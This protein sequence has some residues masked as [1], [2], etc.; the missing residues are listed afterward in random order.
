[1]A[2]EE[3][4][5]DQEFLASLRRL[6]ARLQQKRPL[7]R[8]GAQITPS[9]GAS[10]EFKDRRSYVAGD[11]YRIIDWHCYARFER[12]YVR[13]FEH[14]Q[15]YHVHL[16]VDT[17][18]SMVDP[19]P[20]KRAVALRAAFALGYLALCNN[21]RV[22][23]HALHDS[24][25]RLMPPFKGQG[26]IHQIISQLGKV[27]FT[28]EGDPGRALRRF[29][30]PRDGRGMFFLCSDLLGDDPEAMPES[31]RKLGSLGLDGHVVQIMDPGELRPDLQGSVLLQAVEG[32]EQ[33][34]VF[35]GRGEIERYHEVLA[36][37]RQDLEQTCR[38]RRM[39]Y[40]FWPTDVPFDEGMI[41]LL[42]RGQ[43][44]VGAR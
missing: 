27:E 11:D 22:S 3:E 9:Q 23:F 30:P 19:F 26:H 20:Q 16:V 2:D 12:L 21:H 4:L 6:F 10:R 18:R 34:R 36:A 1:M 25:E 38:A 43:V 42:E 37:W 5:F 41:E 32:E 7:Q 31:L 8:H 24:V 15:E 28:R 29:R 14:V 40:L 39:D 44:L 33:R 35:L 13:L 17:S